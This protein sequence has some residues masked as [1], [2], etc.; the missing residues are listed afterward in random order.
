MDIYERLMNKHEQRHNIEMG[1]PIFK[2]AIVELQK[3]QAKITRL[4]AIIEEM[5]QIDDVLAPSKWI[6]VDDRLPENNNCVL[7]IVLDKENLKGWHWYIVNYSYFEYYTERDDLNADNDGMVSK[8]GWHY[9]RESEGE[10]DYLTFDLEGKVTYWQPLPQPPIDEAMRK[11]NTCNYMNKA[12]KVK[13]SLAI[14]QE[15]QSF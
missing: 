3:Q 15:L 11:D 7:A 2:D 1:D 6:S 10:Y 4:T 13:Q 9:E 12:G 5:K 14:N 8:K